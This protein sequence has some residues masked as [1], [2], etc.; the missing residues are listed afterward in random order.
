MII[1]RENRQVTA[2]VSAAG[3]EPLN[4]GG[5]VISARKLVVTPSGL[6]E[7]AVWIDSQDRVL[8]LEIPSTGFVAMRV[9]APK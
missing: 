3:N 8:K 4:V 6:P 1:P 9:A 7:R 2:Q 5:T